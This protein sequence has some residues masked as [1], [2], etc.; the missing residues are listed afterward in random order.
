MSDLQSPPLDGDG[1]PDVTAPPTKSVLGIEMHRPSHAV[2][3]TSSLNRSAGVSHARVSRGRPL[4]RAAKRSRSSWVW[5]DRS[6]PLGRNWRTR[7]FQF[8][9]LP[10]CQGL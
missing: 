1:A 8:S 4:R 2:V 7:P 6:V 9:L 5:T 3:A 10:R